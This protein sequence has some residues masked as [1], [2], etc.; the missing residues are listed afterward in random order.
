MM[1]NRFLSYIK[2][3]DKIALKILTK[4]LF[5]CFSLCMFSCII[6]LTYLLFFHTQLTY[7]LGI[8]LFRISLIF[9]IEFIVCAFISDL[10]KKQLI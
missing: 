5:S 1:L 9:S 3:L 4:G 7:L 8:T 10:I 2:K 6:L